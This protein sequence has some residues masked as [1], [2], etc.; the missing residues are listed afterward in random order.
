MFYGDESQVSSERYVPYG[1]LVEKDSLLLYAV[2]RCMANI[3]S[4]LKVNFSPFN[5][6]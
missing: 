1:Y 5:A 4:N 3:G 6:N 2:N